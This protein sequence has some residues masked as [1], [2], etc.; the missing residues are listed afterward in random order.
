MDIYSRTD[1]SIL[2]DPKQ[3]IERIN[4]VPLQQA[5]STMLVRAGQMVRR[6]KSYDGIEYRR[7]TVDVDESL[8]DKLAEAM[9]H[10]IKSDKRKRVLAKNM[11]K[12]LDA[13]GATIGL[14]SAESHVESTN[15]TSVMHNIIGVFLLAIK[16]DAAA[17]AAIE[18]I[19]NGEKP[20][21][22]VS[23]TLEMF[24]T[25]YA[26]EKG[27][28]KGDEINASFKDILLR[29][30]EKTREITIRTVSTAEKEV[31]S[32]E[33]MGDDYRDAKAFIQSLD[34]D[35]LPISP[36]DHIKMRIRDAGFSVG[37]VTGRQT[38]VEHGIYKARD[39]SERGVAGKKN[40]IAKFNNN[41]LD[42]LIVNRAGS[43]GLSMHASE[44][45]PEP[46][47]PRVMFIVQAEGDI[48]NH[49]QMLGRVNRTGQVVLPRYA[50]FSANVPAELRLAA[51]LAKKMGSLNA[52]TTGGK[53]SAV[54]DASSPDF[55]K[56]TAIRL[57]CIGC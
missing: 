36:I 41:Q 7:E 32:E 29:Y 8:V 46:R 40:T 42:A 27:I 13:I 57:H 5:A 37:E 24:I 51:V 33:D 49:M 25:E 10:I 31:L 34:L 11:Q 43:T 30:L 21:L 1:L 22:T 20:V 53:R 2:G 50:Q 48:N 45:F 15:F 26:K 35:G 52:N 18:A 47:K 14:D 19:K 17:D 4:S 44:K 56:N 38:V 6:E 3:I 39:A 9:E 16:A 55:M 28:S 23:N 54:E 12:Q